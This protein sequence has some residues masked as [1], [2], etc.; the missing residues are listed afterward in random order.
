MTDRGPVLVAGGGGFIGRAVV[1]RLVRDGVDVSAMTAHPSRS[2]ARI[3]RMGARAVR[4]DVLDPATLGPAVAG[5]S[6][7]VQALTFPTFPVQ[8]PRKGFTF[9]AFDHVGTERL[10]TAAARAGVGRF[11][12]VSGSGA[13][14]DAA[15]V[16]YR[17]KWAGEEAVR[18]AGIDHAIIRPSWI[19]G[20]EDRALNRFVAFHRFLPFVPVVGDGDQRLQPVFVDDV[21]VV[22]ARAASTDGPNGTFEVGGPDVRTMN[23]V[24][25]VMMDVRGRRKPLV[26]VPVWM[27][28]TAGAF[29]RALPNPPLSPQAVD[30]LTGDALADTGP[31]V[32]AFGIR[33]TS[34]EEGLGTYLG[35]RS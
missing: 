21:A 33:L 7:V 13:A 19:Y 22:V 29:A 24:L 16:W 32:E 31:L 26:H 11:V 28:K 12:F 3:E 20:P 15:A 34:L 35:P 9:E 8:V 27:A 4:G 18:A 25:G 23:Q 17:A 30:F 6:T 1:R 2:A 14:P 10:V 5:M